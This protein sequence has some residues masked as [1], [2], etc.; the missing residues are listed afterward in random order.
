MRLRLEDI[1]A[2]RSASHSFT[3]TQEDMA[4]FLRY[5]G[6]D[7]LIHTDPDFSARHGFREPIVYGG[8]MLAQLSRLLGTMMPGSCG[9]STGWSIQYKKPLYVGEEA[10]LRAEVVHVSP[11]TRSVS[12]K[13]EIL[14]E[15]SIIATGKTESLI[16][17]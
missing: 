3:V 16:L 17:E 1:A 6:D 8:L 14:R 15:N 12:L 9:I 7:S 13:F 5:S 4:M 2:G 10:T 11:A